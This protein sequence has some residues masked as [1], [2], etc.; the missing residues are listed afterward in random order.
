MLKDDIDLM[1]SLIRESTYGGE[2]ARAMGRI[3]DF[4]EAQNTAHNK[5]KL[6]CSV[7]GKRE[8]TVLLCAVCNDMRVHGI[9]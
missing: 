4:V 2:Y 9:E 1:V 6:S 5:Q 8:G 3:K 7:C